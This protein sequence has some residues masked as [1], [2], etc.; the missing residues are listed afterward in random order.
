ML[1]FSA[2]VKD[3]ERVQFLLIFSIDFFYYLK[4]VSLIQ[5]KF[6]E[7]EKEAN[8]LTSKLNVM[9]EKIIIEEQKQMKLEKEKENVILKL[10]LDLKDA[11]ENV[12]SLNYTLNETQLLS[13]N[14]IVAG[15]K[16]NLELRNDISNI[17][18]EK[19][20]LA[21][22]SKEKLESLE[23]MLQSA[24]VDAEKEKQKGLEEVRLLRKT[25]IDKIQQIEIQYQKKMAVVED[26]KVQEINTLESKYVNEFKKAL[27]EKSEALSELKAAA[28]KR[29]KMI[30]TQWKSSDESLR[31]T[32]NELEKKCFMD[33]ADFE[34]N[35]LDLEMEHN[36]IISMMKKSIEDN[37]SLKSKNKL[38][39]SVIQAFDTKELE[40]ASKMKTYDLDKEMSQLQ[41]ERLQYTIEDLEGKLHKFEAKSFKRKKEHDIE[42]K[43]MQE[44][45]HDSLE[46]LKKTNEEMISNMNMK[47]EENVQFIEISMQQKLKTLINDHADKIQSLEERLS[48]E[49]LHNDKNMKNIEI[50]MKEQEE[51]YVLKADK[52]N[53]EHQR[54]ICKLTTQMEETIRKNREEFSLMK[55]KMWEERE[56]QKMSFAEKLEVQRKEIEKVHKLSMQQAVEKEN[57]KMKHSMDFNI[58]TLE[59][60]LKD[61]YE[62]KLNKMKK[63][64]FVEKEVFETQKRDLISESKSLKSCN[65]YIIERLKKKKR[66]LLILKKSVGFAFRSFP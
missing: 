1:K 34:K 41:I 37:K 9:E 42:M 14:R 8:D 18:E 24:K 21:S 32:I 39:E 2:L 62:M 20:T 7:K 11:N 36:R 15:E 5:S 4:K 27:E 17:I 52:L 58:K 53:E 49:K 13:S 25:T 28:E 60:N 48:F 12:N 65:S 50:D 29:E 45:H 33:K 46:S 6:L 38:L 31:A 40:Q 3:G 64:H 22:K 16:R 44:E 43:T 10:N 23:R 56:S 47:H 63:A 51:L 61:N 54:E 19:N 26:T 35:K 66:S 30:E 59:A 57:R 55:K